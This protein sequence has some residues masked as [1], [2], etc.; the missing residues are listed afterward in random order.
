MEAYRE[1]L[2]RI[3][4]NIQKYEKELVRVRNDARSAELRGDAKAHKALE[5]QGRNLHGKLKRERE[6]KRQIV[7]KITSGQ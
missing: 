4:D 7:R 5:K 6:N 3:E 2:I 1:Q